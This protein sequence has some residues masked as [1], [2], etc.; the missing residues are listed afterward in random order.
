MTI[1]FPGRIVAD[2]HMTSDEI[3]ITVRASADEPLTYQAAYDA[4]LAILEDAFET[5]A[6]PVHPVTDEDIE[7]DTGLN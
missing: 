1:Y 5:V 3:V 7:N 4:C 6:P 2:Y